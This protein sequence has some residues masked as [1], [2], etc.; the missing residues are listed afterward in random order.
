MNSLWNFK[1]IQHRGVSNIFFI[2]PDYFEYRRFP[3]EN[4]PSMIIKDSCAR[5]ISFYFFIQDYIFIGAVDGV[6]NL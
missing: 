2:C 3:W 4:Y 1:S 5:D 6:G